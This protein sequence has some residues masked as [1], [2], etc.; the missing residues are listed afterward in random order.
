M[1]RCH[2]H[3]IFILLLLL[4]VSGCAPSPTPAPGQIQVLSMNS[5]IADVVAQ[6]GGTHIHLE[7]LMP[8]GTDPH[9]YSP[10]PQD[11]VALAQAQVIFANGAGL[12]APFQ[13]LIES[14]GAAGRVVDLSTHLN[15][16]T[17]Q[18]ET[19]QQSSGT[20]VDPH[21]W[22][23]P[24]NVIIWVQDIADSLA[25]LDPANADAYRANASAYRSELQAL[26][27][28]IRTQVRQVPESNRRI[29][30]DHAVLGYFAARYGFT[31]E[32]TITTSF[33][34]GA[35]PSAQEL[36]A[37]EDRINQFGV[38]ALF[39]T[40]PSLQNLADQ[41]AADTHI[42]AVWL[43]HA[44]LTKA[45]GPAPTYL[46]FMRYDVNAIVSALR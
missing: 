1:K 35:S 9:E 26:D 43:Y 7:T 19:A 38:K 20:G 31:T 24:N 41:V 5:I 16:L 23:D 3:P 11:V 30:S 39:F 44:T 18:Q 4:S 46:D 45:D 21:T 32:G 42:S 37:L 25:S 8:V 28:W 27:F 22:M 36:A 33:S 29:V 17:M 14:A 10:R 12:E 34:T 2:L 15:L 40:E 13:T 6:V